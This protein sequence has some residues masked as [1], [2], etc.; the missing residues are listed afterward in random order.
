MSPAKTLSDGTRPVIP[1]ECEG[2]K[3]ISPFAR[4]D[5]G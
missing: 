4:N 3:R 1:S 5:K 2:T